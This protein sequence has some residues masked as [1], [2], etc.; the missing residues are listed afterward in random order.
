MMQERVNYP[1]SAIFGPSH[2]EKAGGRGDSVVISNRKSGALTV[3]NDASVRDTPSTVRVLICDDETRLVA[4]TA[5][6]LREFGYDVLT[7]ENGEGAVERVKHE[8]VDVVILDVNL[9]G[10]DTLA[11]AR[12]LLS[13]RELTIVL[14]SGFTEEDVE[15]ELLTLPG[16]K[17][18]LA[19]PYS[20][21]ALSAT[22]LDVVGSHKSG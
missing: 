13:Q 12:Q 8:P 11:I 10:E 14:S 19:K 16:V 15:A 17:A 4:L 9:P 5:G 22:I 18:F 1:N 20:I 2:T 21:E 6:L 7:V 3:R